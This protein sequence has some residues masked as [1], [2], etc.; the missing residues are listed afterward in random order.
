MNAALLP[1]AADAPPQGIPYGTFV[2]DPAGFDLSTLLVAGT[3]VIAIQGMNVTF[4]SS[5]F[6]LDFHLEA[7]I[8]ESGRK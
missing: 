1:L 3:N 8:I 6:N 7:T 4:S 5:D 2:V